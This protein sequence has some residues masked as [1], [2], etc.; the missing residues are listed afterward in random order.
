VLSEIFSTYYLINI[1]H[2][3]YRN[4]DPL[5]IFKPFLG[6]D[7]QASDTKRH[8]R[9]LLLLLIQETTTQATTTTTKSASR[10]SSISS[11]FNIN[12]HRDVKPENM[13]LDRNGN[14]KLADFGLA[15]LFS[16]QGKEK[17]LVE[18]CGS[19]PYAAPELALGVPYRAQPIDVWSAG[20]VLFT[21]LVGS[22]HTLF[23]LFR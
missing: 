22:E 15:A 1:V 18:A 12:A 21:I 5:A 4:P 13:L 3:D 14:L 11:S 8:T 17:K 2:N 7:K 20:I 6:T 19:A 10:N 16:Y 9:F 23:K